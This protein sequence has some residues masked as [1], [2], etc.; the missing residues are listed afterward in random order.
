MKSLYTILFV[1]F[2]IVS[3]IAMLIFK[4]KLHPAFFILTTACYIILFLLYFYLYNSFSKNIKSRL[5]NFKL[6]D[7]STEEA[8]L[9]VI[10]KII[11]N[12]VE[13][14]NVL[15]IYNI[16]GSISEMTHFLMKNNLLDDFL[17]FKENLCEL[18]N[19]KIEETKDER[20]KDFLERFNTETVQ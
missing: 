14:F 12:Q 1:A 10:C 6:T 19:E 17:Q 11:E 15:E 5:E 8:D 20:Q 18:I 7:T 2:H 4:D 3:F 13:E 9:A 16:L